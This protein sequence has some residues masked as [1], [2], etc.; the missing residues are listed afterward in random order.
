MVPLYIQ[1]H[2]NADNT[3]MTKTS[4]NFSEGLIV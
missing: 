4:I 3:K 1:K 2:K